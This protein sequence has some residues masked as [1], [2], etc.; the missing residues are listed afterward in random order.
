MCRVS[1][2]EDEEEG[3]DRMC[4]LLSR[5]DDGAMLATALAAQTSRR[6]HPG[7]GGLGEGRGG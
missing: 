7:R 4:R 1:V 3:E 2:N 5:S 6:R